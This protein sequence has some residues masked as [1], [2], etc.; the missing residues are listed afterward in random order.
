MSTSLQSFFEN[1][2]GRAVWTFAI[3]GYP[4]LFSSSS[5]WSPD[6]VGIA[7]KRV[8][9]GSRRLS[10]SVYASDSATWLHG[11]LEVDSSMSMAIDG[12][13]GMVSGGGM[14][15]K[16]ARSHRTFDRAA[17]GWPAG[18]AG[19][20]GID[21]APEIGMTPGIAHGWLAKSFRKGDTAIYINEEG[22][23]TFDGILTSLAGPCLAWVGNECV[24]VTGSAAQSDGTIMLS[25]NAEATYD[26]GRGM[27]RA[28][29]QNHFVESIGGYSATV[30]SMPLG[31]IAGKPCYLWL[32]F[33]DD[34]GN[35][36]LDD[37]AFC[38]FHGRVK[39]GVTIKDGQIEIPIEQWINH[40]KQTTSG[41][42]YGAQI[43]GYHFSRDEARTNNYDS[44]AHRSPHLIIW[45]QSST[46]TMPRNQ[47]NIWLCG[48]SQNVWFETIDEVI[49]ALN[50]ELTLCADGDAG[51]WSGD[52]VTVPY[53]N[54]SAAASLGGLDG[55]TFYAT[56]QDGV[57]RIT[58][59]RS[60][61]ASNYA[62][63]GPLAWV[64]G[65]GSILTPE[66]DT[67]AE[68]WE[69]TYDQAVEIMGTQNYQGYYHPWMTAL[70]QRD[71]KMMMPALRAESSIVPGI[72]YR[73][74]PW[75]PPA[76]YLEQSSKEAVRR[77]AY[78]LDDTDYSVARWWRFAL[79]LDSGDNR[80]QIRVHDGTDVSSLQEFDLMR[81]GDAADD[82]L[83]TPRCLLG[84]VTSTGTLDDGTDYIAFSVGSEPIDGKKFQFSDD[85]PS[86]T[87]L[88][89]AG[90]NF[91]WPPL[92]EYSALFWHSYH[93]EEDPY[94]ISTGGLGIA[95][96]SLGYLIR[97]MVGA[98][99]I[100]RIPGSALL[101]MVP[102]VDDEETDQLESIDWQS[103]WLATKPI[104][105]GHGY[106]YTTGSKM[107]TLYEA[108]AQELALHDAV[109]S[110]EPDI[111]RG[112]WVYR[113]RKRGEV[114]ISSAFAEGRILDAS[115]I[116]GSQKQDI[117][118]ND[119]Y[120]Y[121][122][123]VARSNYDGRDH[124][125]EFR[126]GSRF[127]RSRCGGTFERSI[128]A[129]FS[130]LP[131]TDTNADGDAANIAM[132]RHFAPMLVAS[133][134]D[135][136]LV[137][138]K[139]S[140][141]AWIVAMLGNECIITDP[142]I[143]DIHTGVMGITQKPGFIQ[144]ITHHYGRD[145]GLDVQIALGTGGV[146]G[147]APA[148]RVLGANTA[149][150]SVSA[151][152]TI[153]ITPNTHDFTD[154]DDRTD[155]SY[156]ANYSWSRS[157][158]TYKIG[159]M[160]PDY[161]VKALIE[162][163]ATWT[164]VSGTISSVNPTSNTATLS[165]DTT[166]F[167]ATPD[168]IDQEIPDQEMSEA[169]TSNWE[170]FLAGPISQYGIGT[171]SK[172]VWSGTNMAL[173]IDGLNASAGKYFMA[174][175]VVNPFVEGKKYRIQWRLF[176]SPSGDWG[177]ITWVRSLPN[178]TVTSSGEGLG[179]AQDATVTAVS[180][181]QGGE[182]QFGVR[183]SGGTAGHA[184]LDYLRV[185]EVVDPEVDGDMI[186]VF[187]LW[188][189]CEAEQRRWFCAADDDNMIDTTVPG[190]SWQP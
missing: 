66:D 53:L 172:D 33:V 149:I 152:G 58:A 44:S 144:R 156:F 171:L 100:P 70:W 188:G 168:E 29:E 187:D 43:K 52:G 59:Y 19:L 71:D 35:V 40:L 92:A 13:S 46:D 110:Y 106:R 108:L 127:A 68:T 113:F 96:S 154:D 180:E 135:K 140:S 12:K 5:E 61:G 4:Y 146:Y 7:V 161:A 129:P 112:C 60:G 123:V 1:G 111:A 136:P 138:R 69:A 26:T 97:S 55:S 83:V 139:L 82:R 166:G 56:Y 9:L 116:V 151:S 157:T 143:Q 87:S 31:S 159:S 65:L 86:A 101:D 137:T 93:D 25:V 176:A 94:A 114:N 126:V 11:S 186:L 181:A 183:S 145:F 131:I 177:N 23:T 142:T 182:F 120:K 49:E 34:D 109:M 148:M 189:N 89:Y 74:L 174:R 150:T 64:F 165:L 3:A 164:A 185:W 73:K 155:L 79:P 22:S 99:T 104:V 24:L 51:Q 170:A 167:P 85:A 130:W 50:I 122:A 173:R 8:A 84:S 80:F 184:L 62:V 37:S 77:Y 14:S 20:P 117:K 121:S 115:N 6:A 57:G 95:A 17:Y 162:N 67:G 175:L 72:R 36:I 42:T 15:V 75:G 91:K 38:M 41:R 48:A 118:H 153:N 134:R 47:Q 178:T 16:I 78:Q 81:F 90:G 39:P 169:G 103:L 32:S 98:W 179:S 105:P 190:H 63:G 160:N 76:Y 2:G 28:R 107:P 133:A 128:E 45:Y 18:N 10:S 125:L 102:D 27:Y 21:Y 30:T 163:D 54:F 132:M 88:Y 147:W 158:K 124:Q 119:A 141:R